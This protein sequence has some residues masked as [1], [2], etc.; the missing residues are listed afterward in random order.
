MA[1]L[2][3]APSAFVNVSWKAFPAGTW[4]SLVV[5]CRSLATMTGAFGSAGP[6]EGTAAPSPAL[7]ELQA[8]AASATV[9]R[10]RVATRRFTGGIPLGGRW[11]RSQGGCPGT[12]RSGAGA[13]CG[14]SGGRGALGRA[15]AHL[16]EASL[17]LTLD[18][19]HRVAVGA[20]EV[21]DEEEDQRDLDALGD[22][23]GR[24][25]GAL[26]SP[27]DD[28]RCRVAHEA[29]AD[30]PAEADRERDRDDHGD[31]RHRVARGVEREQQAAERAVD[32]GRAQRQGDDAEAECDTGDGEVAVAV[33][34]HGKP[35]V[36]T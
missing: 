34:V 19:L 28:R 8:A 27:R 11:R 32:V 24:V 10:A 12:G 6:A 13:G 1:T 25:E 35:P 5:N 2:C 36:V 33:L 9:A 17:D 14:R 21:H 18:D 26:D 3:G 29:E 20:E 23:G 15:E 31:R 30:E 7:V 16:G 4:T 22:V